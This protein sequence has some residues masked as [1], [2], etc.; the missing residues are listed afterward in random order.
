MREFS[1]ICPLY[2]GSIIRYTNG[3]NVRY[4]WRRHKWKKSTF[5]SIY[6]FGGAI[7]D[8]FLSPNYFTCKLY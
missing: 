6:N 4:N 1:R 5:A 3:Y 8:V 2:D 7:D